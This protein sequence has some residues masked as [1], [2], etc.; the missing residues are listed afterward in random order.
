MQSFFCVQAALERDSINIYCV[1]PDSHAQEKAS[2]VLPGAHEIAA[3]Q[4][5]SIQN[6][7]QIARAEYALSSVVF[8]FS[9]CNLQCVLQR[10]VLSCP[11]F[12][13]SCILSQ[14]SAL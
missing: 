13:L 10:L 9:A 7:Q 8:I 5:E 1:L 11:Y 12:S 6:T 4:N 2:V 3:A 14:R